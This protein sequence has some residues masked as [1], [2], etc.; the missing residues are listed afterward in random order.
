[1]VYN[2]FTP[3]RNALGTSTSQQARIQLGTPG[4]EEF[5]ERGPNCLNYAQ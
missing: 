3:T 4:G 1:M 2:V 5:S